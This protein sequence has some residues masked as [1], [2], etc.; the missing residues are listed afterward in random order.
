M[1]R[2]GFAIG[3]ALAITLAAGCA[4]EVAG[5]EEGYDEAVSETDEALAISSGSTWSTGGTGTIRGYT[6]S[7]GSCWCEPGQTEPE[8]SCTGFAD[9]CRALGRTFWC[10]RRE[11]V[12]RCE[13]EFNAFADYC[14]CN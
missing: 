10:C 13:E 9:A 5:P 6:C 14:T 4:A 11:P 1:S 8:R 12:Y 2:I 3:W 7:G